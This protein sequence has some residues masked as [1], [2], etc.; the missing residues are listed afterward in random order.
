[1]PKTPNLRRYLDVYRDMS[2]Y[3]WDLYYIRPSKSLYTWS[4]TTWGGMN[5]PLYSHLLRFGWLVASNTYLLTR[6]DWRMA[7]GCIW[8][9]RPFGKQ[10]YSPSN[11]F[12]WRCRRDSKKRTPLFWL[13]LSFSLSLSLSLSG[14][15]K[16]VGYW[17]LK[18][19]AIITAPSYPPVGYLDSILSI[20]KWK[21]K[22]R[23]TSAYSKSNSKAKI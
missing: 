7:T 1:M 16:G 10:V 22:V 13:S 14:T 15:L 17:D 2:V 5:E 23:K 18:D 20:Q 11:F 4:H 3:F 8:Q 6:Y 12:L 9:E 19:V 21:V